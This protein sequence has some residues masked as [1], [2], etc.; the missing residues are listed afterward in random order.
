MPGSSLRLFDWATV[1]ARVKVLHKALCR[2]RDQPAEPLNPTRERILKAELLSMQNRGVGLDGDEQTAFNAAS[3][4]L[5]QLSQPSS[6]TTFW[7]P[8][9]SGR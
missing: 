7:M 9:S 8:P 3:E 1:S 4:R 5:A 2:L 6:A